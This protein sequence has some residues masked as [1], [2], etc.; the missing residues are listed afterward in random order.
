MTIFICS[1]QYDIGQIISDQ[2]TSKENMCL[3]FKDTDKLSATIRTLK[4]FPDLL[5][6]D[7]TLYN[8]NI[9]NIYDYFESVNIKIPTIFYNDPI[10]TKSSRTIHWTSQLQL[11]QPKLIQH[12]EDNYNKIFIK[13]EELIE[14]EEL[15]PYIKLMQKPLD[16]P[17]NLRKIPLTLENIKN[18]NFDYI[19]DFKERSN[20]PNNLF[21][22]LAL[23]QKHRETSLSLKDIKD[24]YKND[25]REISEQSLKVML[26]ELRSKIRDDR[27]C[28]FIIKNNN[29]VYSFIRFIS[30]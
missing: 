30:S 9:F 24:L 14:S 15:C 10:I 4:K 13:L 5:I 12:K 19:Y 17:D 7:Y 29:G 20:L 2:L 18:Q 1:T 6:L 26:S 11:L 28:K 21:Y 16:L 3:L 27:K 25:N 8:H 22:L 23:L